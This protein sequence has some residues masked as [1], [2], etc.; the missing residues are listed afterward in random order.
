[1]ESPDRSRFGHVFHE[2]FIYDFLVTDFV[3][4]ERLIHKSCSLPLRRPRS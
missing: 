1:M 4:G 2:K 3:V